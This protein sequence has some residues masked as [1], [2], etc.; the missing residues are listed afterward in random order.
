MS[1]AMYIGVQ[2]SLHVLTF[3]NLDI[4]SEAKLLNYM[5]ISFLFFGKNVSKVKEKMKGIALCLVHR[6][7]AILHS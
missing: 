2:K 4:H 1:A 6:G 5:V 7:Y 3:S